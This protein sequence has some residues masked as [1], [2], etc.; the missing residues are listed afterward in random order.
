L[1]KELKV[2]GH[3]VQARVYAE[4]PKNFFPSPGKLNVFR[5]PEDKSIRIETGYAEGREVTPY[6]DPMLAKVIV[7]GATRDQ[8]IDTL[9]AALQAFDIQ[10][11]KHNIPAVVAILR[12]DAFRSGEVHTGIVAQV[13]TRA[14]AKS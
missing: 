12:S 4:D 2:Q 14:K 6:Y 7:K 9:V 5:P 8:A 10:G 3:A 11:L 13:L 1:P